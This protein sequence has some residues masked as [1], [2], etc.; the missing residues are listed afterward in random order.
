MWP[1]LP[2]KC[3]CAETGTTTSETVVCDHCGPTTNDYVYTGES[4]SCT[5][6]ENQDSLTVAFQKLDFFLCGGGLYQHVVDQLVISEE[7][8]TLIN[9]VF[10]CNL[11]E[12]CGPE[13]TTT[14]TSTSTS[15]STS[16]TTTTTTTILDCTLEGT[17]FQIY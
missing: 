2:K 6:I 12:E 8:S 1:I 9:D 4:L 13:P 14:T 5:G 17:A 10:D 11:I 15:T 16:S 7:F 3:D